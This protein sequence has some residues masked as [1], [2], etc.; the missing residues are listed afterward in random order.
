MKTPSR[1]HPAAFT[2]IELMAVVTIIV[3]LAGIV[4]AGLGFVNEKQAREKA[5]V[6]IN[7][8]SRAIEEYKMDMGQYP[9]TAANTPASGDISQQL[10][11]ALF[12]D[13]FDYTNPATPPSNWTKARTI[14]VPELDP[15]TSKVGWVNPTTATTPPAN[16]NIIDPWGNN[17][18]Y[19]K[20]SNAQNP[21]FDLW[22]VG[23]D[24]NT[25][26]GNP[27]MSLKANKDDIRNF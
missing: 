21:D 27:S 3:I 18:R 4:V 7:L 9:G 26:V 22:S 19:R 20:G 14:Y 8:L 23:K 12:K 2:L 1:R 17:Y 16:Q 10:Y 25:N 13:G 24:G 6:Q 5:N 11:Q 15:R